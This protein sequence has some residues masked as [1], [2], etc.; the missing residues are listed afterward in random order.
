[1]VRF[2]T[3]M[4]LTEGG[5][6]EPDRDDWNDVCATVG[7]QKFFEAL[8]HEV[9]GLGL[10][11]AEITDESEDD[12]QRLRKG[13]RGTEVMG[14]RIEERECTETSDF[15]TYCR[16]ETYGLPGMSVTWRYALEHAGQLGHVVFRHGELLADFEGPA[17]LERFNEVW[18]RVF[19][20]V[21]T[22]EPA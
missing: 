11:A 21:P 22:F 14:A 5:L 2:M 15:P 20:V 1:M 8:F 17:A 16:W 18:R 10:P 7:P 3:L 13:K 12:I 6:H 19:G 9:G 4:R